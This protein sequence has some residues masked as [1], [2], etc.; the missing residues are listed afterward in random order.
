MGLFTQRPEEPSEWAGLP[1]EPHTRGGAA[2]ELADEP[3]PSAGSIDLLFGAPTGTT[4]SV[5]VPVS[6]PATPGDADGDGD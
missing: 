4:A 5:E 2:D 3:Q 1:A 6:E